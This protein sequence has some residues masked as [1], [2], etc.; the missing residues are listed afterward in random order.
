MNTEPISFQKVLDI[1]LADSKLTDEQY[2]NVVRDV[3]GVTRSGVTS[4]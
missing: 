1:L 4:A 3:F 2:V